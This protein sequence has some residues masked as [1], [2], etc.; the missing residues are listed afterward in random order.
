MAGKVTWYGDDASRQ[1]NAEMKRR[2]AACAIA[3][4]NH[5]KKLIGI[6][7]TG[8]DSNGTL[9]PNVNPSKPGDP[10][11]KQGGELQGSVAWSMV[12]VVARV[13]THIKYGRWLEL[14]TSKMAARPWLRRALFEM[15]P[16]INMLLSK[17][18][19]LKNK[20]K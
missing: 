20:T 16:R 12:G 2:L 13:G 8:V 14:G 7:G 6:D 15:T 4:T 17:P 5:A 18:M 19:N 1:I 11:H 9:I 10:P 3:V